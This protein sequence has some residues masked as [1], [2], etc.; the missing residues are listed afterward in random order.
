MSIEIVHKYDVPA[1][2]DPQGSAELMKKVVAALLRAPGLVEIR[3]NHN[4]LGSPEVRATSVWER[5]ADWEAARGSEDLI[6]LEAKARR[7]VSNL[8]IELGE[9]L[10]L[11]SQ[12]LRP[13]R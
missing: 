2:A 10:N 12:P 1:D 13:E 9:P 3:A 11:L 6:A 4:L 7:Y 5:L 8:H